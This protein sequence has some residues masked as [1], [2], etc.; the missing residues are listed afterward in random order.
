MPF[1]SFSHAKDHLL[2]SSPKQESRQ[3]RCSGLILVG[4]SVR[5]AAESARRAGLDVIAVDLFGDLQTRQAAETWF[6]VTEV[7]DQIA[8]PSGSNSVIANQWMAELQQHL[9]ANGLRDCPPHDSGQWMLG[10]ISRW[11]GCERLLVPSNDHVG[12]WR[13]RFRVLQSSDSSALK[14]IG[15]TLEQQALAQAPPFVAELAQRSGVDTPLTRFSGPVPSGWL[16]KQFSR[17]G[18]LGVHYADNEM[19]DES[20]FCQAPVAGK[21]CG[22][23]F[24]SDGRHCELL[25]ICRA[26]HKRIGKRPFVYAGA[27]GPV[28]VSQ[29]CWQS[30]E[31]IGRELVDMTGLSGPLNVDLI[32]TG[33]D[34]YLLECNPR[35]SGSMELIEAAWGQHAALPCSVF[36]PFAR[37]QQRIANHGPLPLGQLGVKHVVFAKQASVVDPQ[38]FESVPLDGAVSG[39]FRWTD[40]PFETTALEA[41]AP[42]ATLIGGLPIKGSMQRDLSQLFGVSP[43]AR[44]RANR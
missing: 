3:S 9:Q 36:E 39:S 37:W 22:A 35:Y 31:R 13:T 7:V 5:A 41:G 30:V 23:T 44:R 1:R 20:R 33:S 15:A 17:T 42:I 8:R 25:G 2:N 18:G 34:V 14:V 28:K 21:A 26:L 24:V 27:V 16:V 6:S 40:V 10:I 32:L 29:A 38:H 11:P 43:S 4:A 19:L 12:D